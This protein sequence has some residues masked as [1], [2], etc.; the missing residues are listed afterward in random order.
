MKMNGLIPHT[1]NSSFLS[2]G[3]C[4]LTVNMRGTKISCDCTLS[5]QYCTVNQEKQMSVQ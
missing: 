2:A 3:K 1:F 4:H 5:K